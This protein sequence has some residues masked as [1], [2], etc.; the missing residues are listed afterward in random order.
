M[1]IIPP[2]ALPSP[3]PTPPPPPPPDPPPPPPPYDAGPNE[4]YAYVDPNTGQIML[5]GSCPPATVNIQTPPKGFVLLGVDPHVRSGLH[6]FDFSGDFP[7]TV[8]LTKQE[9]DERADPMAMASAAIAASVVA[10]EATAAEE[11]L[12]D[13]QVKGP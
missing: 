1:T 12:D 10:A 6:K 5:T 3:M 11:V 13:L 7:E 9:L 8:A 2:P 4:R